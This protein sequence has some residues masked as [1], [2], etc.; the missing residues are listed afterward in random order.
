MPEENQTPDLEFGGEKRTFE[1]GE[2]IAREGEPSEGW[3][4]LVSGKVGAFKGDL[5]LADFD[6]EGT[7]FGEVGCIL[8]LPRTAS[9][10]ALEPTSL[11]Y[12][13][14][15]L[16]DLLANYPEIAKRILKGMADRLSHTTESW[17]AVQEKK[18]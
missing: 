16:D 5:K 10:K 2:F 4:I 9:L 8:D 1:P 17:W 3:F 13:E 14:N 7:V 15:D 18:S 6:A 11:L 12:V